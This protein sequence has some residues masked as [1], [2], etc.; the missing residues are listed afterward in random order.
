MAFEQLMA[1]ASLKKDKKDS[2]KSKKEEAKKEE[3]ASSHLHG[4]HS[5]HR[6]ETDAAP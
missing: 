5:H 4:F 1:E 2:K 6:K 3:P